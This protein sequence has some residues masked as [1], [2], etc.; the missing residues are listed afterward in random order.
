M[1][2]L[3]G[4]INYLN[5]SGSNASLVCRVGSVPGADI[6][7]LRDGIEILNN[8][9]IENSSNRR[10]QR[11]YIMENSQLHSDQTISKLILTQAQGN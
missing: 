9:L 2:L 8:S 5:V 6:I 7:W 3:K 4:N 11:R 10:M 1:L